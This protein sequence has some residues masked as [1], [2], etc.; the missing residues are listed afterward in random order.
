[1]PYSEVYKDPEVHEVQPLL[2]ELE[3]DA[4]DV[5]HDEQIVELEL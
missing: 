4:H 5:L 3:H 2:D 1:V